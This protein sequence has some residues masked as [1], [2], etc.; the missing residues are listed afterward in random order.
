VELE[1][2]ELVA[3]CGNLVTLADAQTAGDEM[4]AR[5]ALGRLCGSPWH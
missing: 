1:G 4:A 3:L 5:R 2:P